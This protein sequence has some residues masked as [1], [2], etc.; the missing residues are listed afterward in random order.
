MTWLTRR[1]ERTAERN[2]T[3]SNA[4]ARSGGCPCGNPAEVV[5]EHHGTIGSVPFQW[6]TCRDCAGAEA[7]GGDDGKKPMW[8]HLTQC[9]ECGFVGAAGRIGQPYHTYYCYHR[10][11]ERPDDH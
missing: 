7:F 10:P 2:W 4:A 8:G 5:K 11:G 1:R 6:W 3:A 9:S